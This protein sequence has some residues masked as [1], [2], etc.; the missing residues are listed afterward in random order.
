VRVL[1]EASLPALVRRATAVVCD[2]GHRTVCEAL[3]GGVPLVVV[4]MTGDQPIVADQVAR[5]RAGVRV[6]A[7]SVDAARLRMAVERLLTDTRI[8][9]GAERIRDSFAAAPGPAAAMPRLEALADVP[10]P[11]LQ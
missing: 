11:K 9:H 5:A 8:R 4:P 3:A 6:S 2:G 1:P 10:A 7:R